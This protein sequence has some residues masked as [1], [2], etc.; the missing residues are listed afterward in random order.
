[1][2]T[3][4]VEFIAVLLVYSQIGLVLSF[5]IAYMVAAVGKLGNNNTPSAW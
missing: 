5:S 3:F 1:M 4:V 2:V